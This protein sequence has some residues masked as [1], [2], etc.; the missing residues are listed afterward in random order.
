MSA[1]TKSAPDGEGVRSPAQVDAGVIREAR[2]RQRRRRAAVAAAAILTGLGGVLVLTDAGGPT[3]LHRR[4]QSHGGSSV[5][6]LDPNALFTQAP[7][8]GVACGIANSIACDR[9]GLAIWLRHPALD[10]T[11]TIAGR[12]FR[13]DDRI[14]SGAAHAGERT[15]FA[16]FLQPA[17]ITTRLGVSTEHGIHWDG[18]DGPSPLVTLQITQLGRPTIDASV[19]VLLAAGWG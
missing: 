11:A 18:S 4:G 9:V 14:W 19:N 1:L 3:R 12:S 17:G 2:R 13:L 5:L 6:A 7:Y 8:M 15:V 10:V 16:G